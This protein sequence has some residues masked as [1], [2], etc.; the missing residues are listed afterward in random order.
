MFVTEAD[1]QAFAQFAR[2]QTTNGGANLTMTELAARWQAERERHEVNAAI[3]EGLADID[4]GRTVD[5]FESQNRFR[6]E[7]RVPLRS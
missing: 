3:R 5:F 1:I 2:E 4:A 6:H 7:L